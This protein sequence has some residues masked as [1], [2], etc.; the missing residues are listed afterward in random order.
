MP[1]TEPSPEE[2][3]PQRAALARALASGMSFAK[4]GRSVGISKQRAHYWYQKDHALRAAVA[5]KKRQIFD[6]AKAELISTWPQAVQNIKDAIESGDPKISFAVLK[7][8]GVLAAA[9][10]AQD[11]TGERQKKIE[12]VIKLLLLEQTG[13]AKKCPTND[14]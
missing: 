3:D 9:Q 8:C 1:A 14:G 7:E 6:A 12:A 5:Q 10:P 4:A 11:A 13:D 2:L